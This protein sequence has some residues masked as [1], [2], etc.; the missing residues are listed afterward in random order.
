[1]VVK[2]LVL[3]DLHGEIPKIK[4][5]D[6]DAII[7]TGDICGDNIKPY[8]R[9]W[10]KK[11]KEIQADY[12]FDKICPKWKQKLYTKFSYFKGKRILTFLNKQKV[13]VF[14][15]PGNWD[16]T[17]QDGLPKNEDD[18]KDKKIWNKMLKGKNNIFDLEAKKKNFKGII[19]IG[20]GSTSA[21]E[22]VKKIPKNKLKEP[23]Y[24]KTADFRYKFYMKLL[25]KFENW[26]KENKKDKNSKPIILLSHNSPYNTLLDEV[27]M[28]NNYAD[29]EHYGSIIAKKLI[30]KYEPMLCISGHIHEGYGREDIGKTICINAGYG[31]DVNTII[32]VDEKKGKVLDI[33]WLGENKK[34]D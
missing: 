13:P 5:N 33:E 22:I 21:P 34:N 6:F 30:E 23:S 28:K 27:R 4:I 16:P 31:G 15:V 14:L 25:K 12:D 2:F 19:L 7:A 17:P 9:K 10:I 20:H 32:T 8:I 11:R 3:G 26:F 18:N 29:G 24:K 1:M